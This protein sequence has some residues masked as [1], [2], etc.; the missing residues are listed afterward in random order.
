MNASD[1]ERPPNNS[2]RRSRVVAPVVG[3][4][5]HVGALVSMMRLVRE[6]TRDLACGISV[7]ELIS[8]RSGATNTIGMLLSHVAA[9][10]Y[11]T[12]V[13][14]LERRDPTNEEWAWLQPRMELG[15]AG[16]AALRTVSGL[17]LDEDL[18]RT[19]AWLE[20]ALLEVDDVLFGAPFVWRGVHV[21]LHRQIF[22]VM[23]DELR[24]VGQIRWLLKRMRSA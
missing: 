7:E 18:L 17:E 16:F 8:R 11:I 5:P 4:A 10:E 24:H 21:N 9:L 20:H 13:R 22:H 6:D 14:H 2:H 12:V 1:A 3:F 15:E 23:E 19:R